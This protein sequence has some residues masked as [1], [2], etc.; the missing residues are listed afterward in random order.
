MQK[1]PSNIKNMESKDTLKWK[2]SMNT[3]HTVWPTEK[4]SLSY[5]NGI[6]IEN[7]VKERET[8]K[9]KRRENYITEWKWKR[10]KERR[11]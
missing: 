5:F 1:Y 4:A 2:G 10:E 8:W 11:S 7:Y 6:Q 3:E 9:W